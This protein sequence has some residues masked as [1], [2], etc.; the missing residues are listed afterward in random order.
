M[1]RST[2]AQW[3]MYRVVRQSRPVPVCPD[4]NPRVQSPLHPSLRHKIIQPV[5]QASWLSAADIFCGSLSNCA[6]IVQAFLFQNFEGPPLGLICGNRVV[7]EP[8][9]IHVLIQIR[10]CDAPIW[11]DLTFL[12]PVFFE[13]WL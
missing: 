1:Y 10:T 6:L 12:Q 9:C 11:I 3:T 13:G 4:R 5:V 2:S 8:F 7:G